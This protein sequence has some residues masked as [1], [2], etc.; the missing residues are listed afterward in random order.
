MS[1][2]K[3]MKLY[4]YHFHANGKKITEDVFDVRETPRKLYTVDRR[5]IPGIW[6]NCI[7]KD[8]LPRLQVE[9]GSTYLSSEPVSEEEVREK[10]VSPL[11]KER[12]MLEEEIERVKTVPF[13]K[14]V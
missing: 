3:R 9:F 11:L 13:E 4:V 7:F 8:P 14:G 1:E 12:Q 5:H 6:A 2:E 10:L